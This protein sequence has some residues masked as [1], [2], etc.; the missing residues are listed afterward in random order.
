MILLP[1]PQ[2]YLGIFLQLINVY[3]HENNT[4]TMKTGLHYTSKLVSEIE[5]YIRTTITSA[6]SIL[7][8]RTSTM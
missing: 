6:M 1:N 3:M 5:P 2:R 8:H 4:S 7:A